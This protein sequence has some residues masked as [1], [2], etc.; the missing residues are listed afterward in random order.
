[1]LL[2]VFKAVTAITAHFHSQ[3]GLVYVPTAIR[4][5]DFN[6]MAWFKFAAVH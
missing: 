4:A 3:F 2:W 1:M 6:G 5:V